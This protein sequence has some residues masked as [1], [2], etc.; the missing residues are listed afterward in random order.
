M[1]PVLYGP[2]EGERH[3]AG[4]AQI[5]IKAAGEHTGGAFFLAESTLAPRVRRSAAAPPSR[6]P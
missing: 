1:D 5:V 4:P 3:D 6:A 2:G